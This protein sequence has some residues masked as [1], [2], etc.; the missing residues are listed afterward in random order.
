MRRDLLHQDEVMA[1]L[2]GTGV[3]DVARRQIQI[4]FRSPA[5]RAEGNRAIIR[6]STPNR[7]VGVKVSNVLH[8]K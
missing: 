5:Q 2:V 7:H 8:Q 3:Y 4:F 1:V 6:D